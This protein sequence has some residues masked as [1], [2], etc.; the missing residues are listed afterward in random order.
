MSKRPGSSNE[1]AALRRGLFAFSNSKAD[2]RATT[3]VVPTETR[4]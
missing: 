2:Q 4:E 1:K 3:T